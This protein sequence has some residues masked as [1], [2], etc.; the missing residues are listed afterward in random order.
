MKIYHATWPTNVDAILADGINAGWDRRV[1]FANTP[2]YAAGFLS[3]RGGQ[4]VGQKEVQV[5]DKTF[6]VP[7]VVTH[8]EIAV[9][10]VDAVLLSES[11]LE[12]GADHNPEFYPA[13]LEVIAHVGN[14]PS[15][16]I[17]SV[18]LYSAK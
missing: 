4:I 8:D 9:I 12:V 17:V 3:M 5:G 10:E 7:D 6:M 18:A 15:S 11:D 13:D 2:G 14:V 16:A 1:Y